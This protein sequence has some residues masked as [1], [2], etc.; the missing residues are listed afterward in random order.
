M[1]TS[2]GE[3]SPY[4]HAAPMA[5]SGPVVLTATKS[6]G[7][8]RRTRALPPSDGQPESG[9]AL[10]VRPPPVPYG[11]EGFDMIVQT[12]PEYQVVSE[13]N[14]PMETRDGVTLLA[15]VV[16]PDV[17][18]RFPVLLS[19]I[20]L[21]Q[22]GYEQPQWSTSPLR[23][24]RL[25]RGHAGLSWPLRIRRG[26]RHHLPGDPGRLRRRRVGC[27]IALVQWAGRND[28]PVVPSRLLKNSSSKGTFEGSPKGEM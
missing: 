16:R 7:G 9:G 23:P 5:G 10:L 15:D 19:R 26:V 25:R 24:L 17:P 13:T 21:R 2:S 20:T 12:R 18:G 1:R 14:V 6:I 4:R 22:A 3:R 11:R 27:T 28:R 8:L